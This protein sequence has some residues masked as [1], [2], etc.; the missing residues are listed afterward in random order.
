MKKPFAAFALHRGCG[1]GSLEA[2]VSERWKGT[3]KEEGWA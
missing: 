3:W 1:W 2:G